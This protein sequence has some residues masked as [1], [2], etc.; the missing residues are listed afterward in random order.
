MRGNI[1][2]LCTCPWHFRLTKHFSKLTIYKSL[3]LLYIHKFFFA[4]YRR[5]FFS[6]KF[7]FVLRFFP[8]YRNLG[9]KTRGSL[10]RARNFRFPG[11]ACRQFGKNRSWNISSGKKQKIRGESEKSV[12]G[13][14]RIFWG[15]S[16]DRE[17][18][19][20]FFDIS[21]YHRRIEYVILGK[22]ASRSVK[23]SWIDPVKKNLKNCENENN[24]NFDN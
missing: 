1:C 15:N 22:M 7:F 13:N 20:W 8:T 10:K 14:F 6:G 19:L 11:L 21:D 17:V 16:E 5:N 12:F 3:K 23:K 9:V 4:N 24:K 18:F 2:T